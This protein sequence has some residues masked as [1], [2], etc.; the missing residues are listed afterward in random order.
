MLNIFRFQSKNVT[1]IVNKQFGTTIPVVLIQDLENTGVRGDV[2]SVK[3]GYARNFLI[4]RKVAMYGT[5]ENKKLYAVNKNEK[6]KDLEVDTNAAAWQNENPLEKVYSINRY[7]DARG[8][9]AFP[10]NG[11]AI[12]RFIN[13]PL[14]QYVKISDNQIINQIG[15][16]AVIGLDREQKEY[17][18]EVVVEDNGKCVVV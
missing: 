5:Y 18:I 1:K 9:L 17:E 10:L 13:H 12:K 6:Q 15:S 14:I 7:A 2:V 3:R 8:Y 4:P 16:Y 11:G